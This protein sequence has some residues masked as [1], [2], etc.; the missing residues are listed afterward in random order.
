MIREYRGPKL[1][2]QLAHEFKRDIHALIEKTYILRM[3]DERLDK[4]LAEMGVVEV[5]DRFLKYEVDRNDR[6]KTRTAE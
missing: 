6:E 1:G 5:M 3:L 4:E 2:T